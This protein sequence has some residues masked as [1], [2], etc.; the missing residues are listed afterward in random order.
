MGDV[1]VM[2]PSS[3]THLREGKRD[4]AE[5]KG[6]GYFPLGDPWRNQN[7]ALTQTLSIKQNIIHSN[8][9][10][11]DKTKITLLYANEIWMGESHL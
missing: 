4:G 10:A 2:M 8:K 9:V 1:R 5:G 6:E 11:Y 3:N 7:K